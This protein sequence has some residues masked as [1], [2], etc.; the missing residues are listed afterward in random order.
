[1]RSVPGWVQQHRPLGQILPS[2][3][4]C[5]ECSSS[6]QEWVLPDYR[7]PCPRDQGIICTLALFHVRRHARNRGGMQN[8]L[9]KMSAPA[10]I[11]KIISEVVADIYQSL[12]SV[13]LN[14]TP[15]PPVVLC[16]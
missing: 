16:K 4:L 1:M 7:H 3:D 13:V 11:I 15:S 12:P 9:S 14:K 6:Q 2:A 10:P 5:C 8:D